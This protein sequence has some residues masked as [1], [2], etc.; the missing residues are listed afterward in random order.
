MEESHLIR[1]RIKLLQYIS[2][3]AMIAAALFL[4]WRVHAAF[5][6]PLLPDGGGIVTETSSAT[7]SAAIAW[8]GT[9]F[10]KNN[11]VTATFDGELNK[12]YRLA[13][14]FFACGERQ[15]SR[16]AIIDDLQAKSSGNQK[17]VGEGDT[18]DDAGAI[19]VATIQTEFVILRTGTR[20]EKIWLSFTSVPSHPA[21]E[22]DRIKPTDA[23]AV[24]MLA[25]FGSRVEDRRW[26]LKRDALL[27]YYQELMADTER[28]GKVFE[29]L[30]PVYKESRIAGYV[31][32][33]VGEKDMFHAFGL[34]QNDVIRK[35]NSMPMTSQRRAEY[36]ISEF[37][38]DRVNGFV[39]DIE[40]DGK[41]QKFV[42]L[43]R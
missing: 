18:L 33:V 5:N 14:T 30:K 3:I 29:S 28:L 7:N 26:L 21:A 34:R 6:L 11:A 32:D 41:P 22:S 9:A 12:R 43:I 42:Y 13:G 20:E 38:K 19:L 24:G 35:V 23:D 1:Q 15:Q 31:L 25:R 37:V 40:R 27:Q 16:K 39:L 17:L 4:V 2:G 8:N 36:F 10:P